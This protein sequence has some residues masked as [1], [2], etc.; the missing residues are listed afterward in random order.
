MKARG[1]P[2]SRAYPRPGRVLE[3]TQQESKRVG[4]SPGHLGMDRVWRPQ[5]CRPRGLE[6]KEKGRWFLSHQA[7]KRL[8][9]R[10]PFLFQRSTSTFTIFGAWMVPS[11]TE[12]DAHPLGDP[13]QGGLLSGHRNV[14]P[15]WTLAGD[16]GS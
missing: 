9:V 1:H 10:H 7:E 8:S 13:G 4:T 3:S 12:K 14:S 15:T 11:E 16:K 2:G 5:A 6:G